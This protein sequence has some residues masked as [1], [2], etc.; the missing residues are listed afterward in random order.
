MEEV[1]LSLGS[2][3]G[4]RKSN[5]RRAL[6]MLSRE[7][8][9]KKVSSIYETEPVGYSEQPLFLNMACHIAT[10][11]DPN[12]L[13]QLIKKIERDMGRISG[14]PNSPRPIDIDI[15][16][17][18]D[19]IVKTVDLVIPH[20]RLHERGFVLTPL[21]E[22]APQLLH[23]TL[24]KSVIELAAELDNQKAVRKWQQGEFD[25]H[26]IRRGTF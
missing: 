1:H 23:P 8:N 17:Y 18:S 7:V 12:E 11:L 10:N 5:L 3:M 26:A 2:N 21:L 15:L 14:F 25:V 19:M 4:N 20:P 16:F 24:K 22:L 6:I 13:L 9:L